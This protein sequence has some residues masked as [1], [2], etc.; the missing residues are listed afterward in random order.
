MHGTTRNGQAWE[1]G[2]AHAG[3][4]IWFVARDGAQRGPFTESQIVGFHRD[5]GLRPTDHLWTEALGDWRSVADLLG[6]P[7]APTRPA[8]APPVAPPP[9]PAPEPTAATA[10]API[11]QQGA[12]SQHGAE[13]Y[14]PGTERPL[15]PTLQPQVAPQATAQ[16]P[17]TA[18]AMQP[19]HYAQAQPTHGVPVET[20]TQ[21]I[22]EGGSFK[23]STAIFLI[24]GLLVPLWPISLP[25]FWYLA[26]RSYKKP[27]EVIVR[28]ISG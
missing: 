27:S 2:A 9:P 17:Q 10:P 15:S 11:A 19:Q 7:P 20:Y 4:P 23:L 5:G 12:P 14:V 22:V 21:T 13:V 6:A 25:L 3:E 24:L 16:T 26:Y 8:P 1:N 18:Q 28:Q